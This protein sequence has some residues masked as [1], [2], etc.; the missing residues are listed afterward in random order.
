MK[1]AMIF[2]AGLGTR[3]YPYTQTTPKALVKIHNKTFLEIVIN[4]FL[5]IG[6]TDIIVNV[7]HFSE[8]LIEFLKKK[9]DFGIRIVVS[10]ER[11]QLLDTGGGIKKASWFFED[12]NPFFVHNVDVLSTIDLA[13][14]WKFHLQNK[15]MA[16][17][18]V[19]KRE[20]SRYL[21]FD[22]DNSL[23]GWENIHS[24]EKILVNKR[25]NLNQFAFSGIHILDPSI[26]D[27]L[28]ET[29]KFSIIKAYLRLASRNRIVAFDHTNTAWMDLGTPE[30]LEEAKSKFNF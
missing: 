24:G 17:L 30:K 23:S 18:A 21:L 3:L 19:R 11:D 26:F 27:A 7:H 4:R 6:V 12:G 28:T 8:Q 25:A 1:K 2:A 15:A 9:K 22:Q 5:E 29:G 16:T 13:E 20:T 14:M 10:D